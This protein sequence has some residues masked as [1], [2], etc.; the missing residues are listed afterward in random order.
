MPRWVA[1][2]GLLWRLRRPQRWQQKWRYGHPSVPA[3]VTTALWCQWRAMLA[4]AAG[5]SACATSVPSSPSDRRSWRP[6][7]PWGSRCLTPRLR[8]LQVWL[9][10]VKALGWLLG[11]PA[12]L[13]R[14]AMTGWRVPSPQAATAKAQHAKDCHRLTALPSGTM[15]STWP[16][17]PDSSPVPLPFFWSSSSFPSNTVTCAVCTHWLLR[18]QLPREP[19]LLSVPRSLLST[20]KYSACTFECATLLLFS[21]LQNLQRGSHGSAV[22]GAM[23]SALLL[24]A[25]LKIKQVVFSLRGKLVWEGNQ[26]LMHCAPQVFL[27]VSDFGPTVH[28]LAGTS[29]QQ[30]KC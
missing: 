9:P 7:R 8:Q 25:K 17:S 12:A 22:A 29:P 1:R 10:Q 15:V 2:T 14:A 26:P 6:R 16:L 11:R 23:C 3:A 30:Q 19:F 28:K 5:S 24:I 13:S 18:L 4:T 21:L 20:N 27:P